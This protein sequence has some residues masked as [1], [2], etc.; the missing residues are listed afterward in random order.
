MDK[1]ESPIGL[2]K[3]INNNRYLDNFSARKLNVST[4][5]YINNIFL[6]A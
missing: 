2:F 1:G 5:I 6:N 3:L 4:N